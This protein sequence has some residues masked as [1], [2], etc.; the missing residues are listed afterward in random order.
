MMM[1]TI[2]KEGAE[3]REVRV[4]GDTAVLGKH[5]GCDV[6]LDD[7]RVSRRHARLR[8][9]GAELLLEDLG[10]T[11]G[12]EVGGQSIESE[13]AIDPADDIVIGP[14]HVVARIAEAT[15]AETPPAPAA[16]G[17]S[18]TVMLATTPPAA[19]PPPA[20]PL[21]A[22][23]LPAG[24]SDS[25]L[26]PLAPLAADDS[27]TEIMVNGPEEVFV[28]REGRLE[29]TDVRFP[30]AQALH[31]LILALAREAGR[32][33][34]ERR[35]MLDARMRDGS[36]LNAILPP[37]A[38]R[39]PCLTIRRFPRVRLSAEQLVSV[40]SLS[41]SML[42]FLRLAIQGK[43]SLLVSGGTGSGKTSLLNAL[44]GFIGED[45]RIVTIEDAA[46]L[47]L[48]Q[49]HV[50]PLETRPPDPDGTGEVT[51]RDLV[52]N[53]L[54]MRP[55]RI[56]VGEVRGAEALDML[57][58]M[59]TGHEGSLSTVHANS[60]REALS[61][62]ETLVLFAGADLPPR[63]IREQVVGAIRLVV[64]IAR[65]DAGKRRVTSI[66]ELSG[67]E[68]D[69]FTLGEIFRYD[70]GANGESG[71]RA[72]GYVPRCRDKLAERGL[73]ADNAWFRPR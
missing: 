51:V 34:D 9:V 47:R 50:V 3:T 10:S 30:S 45:Q 66:A 22:T 28:E 65:T 19:M 23:P 29:L 59:N 73:E 14:F 13:R 69:Q 1:L 54:R 57:Q 48:P 11:N 4:A 58:A 49:R 24:A 67:M 20:T 15:V 55:D 5:A 16:A 18:G 52:R 21:A 63:A 72:T 71:F 40:A 61:R 27:V 37:L 39:G 33:I 70:A 44:C 25:K 2:R 6:V 8:A 43:L 31:D 60:P 56:V 17:D 42:G 26:G 32:V 62:L 35:P 41:E 38:L 36:R 64:H 46:E 12:T 53:A 68:G 7:G